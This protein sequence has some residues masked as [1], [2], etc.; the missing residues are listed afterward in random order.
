MFVDG[1]IGSIDFDSVD[2]LYTGKRL[3]DVILDI[4]RVAKAYPGKFC[5]NLPIDLLDELRLGKTVP[6][7]ILGFQIYEELVVEESRRVRPIV[8]PACLRDDVRD[9][10]ER[11]EGTPC[12][13]RDILA[14][15]ERNG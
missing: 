13:P 14:A 11:Q 7:L 8:G 2:P 6:P 9:L 1:E 15:L 10:R 12:G 4:L 3:L 5:F